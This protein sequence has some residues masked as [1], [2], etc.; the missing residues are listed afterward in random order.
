MNQIELI[1]SLQKEIAKLKHQLHIAAINLTD[2]EERVERRRLDLAAW[3]DAYLEEQRKSD[4]LTAALEVARELVAAIDEIPN[5]RPSLEAVREA[6]TRL[7]EA[8]AG[9]D[10]A[11]DGR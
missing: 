8:I 4:Q 7:A 9:L 3:R 5:A 10:S 2:S 1:L 11:S 6:R